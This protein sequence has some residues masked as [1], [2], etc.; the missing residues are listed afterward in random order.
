M[1]ISFEINSSLSN[2]ANL[3]LLGTFIR[4]E[5]SNNEVI[6]LVIPKSVFTTISKHDFNQY[7]SDFLIESGFHE[8]RINIKIQDLNY[9]Q[10]IIGNQP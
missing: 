1:I 9:F 4:E 6:E 2:T 10:L 8:S 5:I 7:F 3:F